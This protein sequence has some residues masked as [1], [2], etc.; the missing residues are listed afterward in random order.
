MSNYCPMCYE[1]VEKIERLEQTLNDIIADCITAIDNG[2]PLRA[3]TLFHI[4]DKAKRA[5]EEGD[6]GK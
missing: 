1:Y 5:V 4:I 2:G 6:G 3:R